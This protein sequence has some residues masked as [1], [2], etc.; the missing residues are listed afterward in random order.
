MPSWTPDNS[1]ILSLLLDVI[2]GTK[3]AIATRQDYCR[4]YDS[5]SSLPQYNSEYFTGSKSE[6]L[7]LPGSDRD[8]MYDINN[9]HHIKVI[10]SSY[11]DLGFS[12]NSVFAMSAENIPPGFV[13]LKHVHPSPLHPCLYQSC[14]NIN[15]LWYLSSDLFIHNTLLHRLERN[16]S[17]GRKDTIQR[18]G[19]SI[20]VWNSLSDRSESGIDHVYSILYVLAKC[21]L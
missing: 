6:G 10:Q 19:P 15:G 8:Y 1:M 5:F 17:T 12:I 18:Q 16:V 14:R 7:D 9:M 11:E 3:E 2:V 4:I 20:E 13:L 21:S